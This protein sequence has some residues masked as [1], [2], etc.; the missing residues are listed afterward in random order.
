MQ[1]RHVSGFTATLLVTSAALCAIRV[2]GMVEP[3]AR[4]HAIHR[5]AAVKDSLHGNSRFEGCAVALPCY[6]H[7]LTSDDLPIERASQ[8]VSSGFA[9]DED[10][11]RLIPTP[12]TEMALN[13]LDAVRASTLALAVGGFLSGCGGGGSDEGPTS[14]D[15]AAG[16]SST[17]AGA[18]SASSSDG[19]AAASG[20]GTDDSVTVASTSAPPSDSTPTLP[21]SSSS[22]STG[23]QGGGGTKVAARSG[24]AMNLGLLAYYS[25][26]APTIDVMK[27]AGDWLTQCSTAN[28]K[29]CTGFASGASSWDTK[30]EAALDL[31]PNGWVRSL[32]DSGDGVHKFRSVTTLL[33]SNN[34]LPPGRYTVRYDGAGTIT[35]SGA[36]KVAGGSSS[37]RD[38]LDLKDTANNFYLT[39]T[40]TDP[41]NYIRNIRVYLPGGACANDLTVFA[42]SAA[43]CTSATGAYVPFESFPAS[44]P[45]SPDFIQ[46]I[47]GFR[48]LRFMDWGKTN[49]TALTS[50]AQRTPATARTWAGANGAPLEAM[51]DLANFIGA[52]A[53]MNVPPHADD[54]YATQLGKLAAA[55][56]TGVSKLDLE[57]GNEPWNYS[58]PASTWM[59]TQAKTRW[60][61][62]VSAGVDAY[63]L[64]DNWYALRL[65]QVCTAAKAAYSGTRCVANSQVANAWITTQILTCPQAAVELGHACAKS[66]DAVA[67]APYFG[68]YISQAKLRSA[69]TP[70]Y[71]DADG[72]L[73][74]LFQEITGTDASGNAATAALAAVGSGASGGSLGQVK[75]WMVATKAATD[76]QGVAMWAYEGGQHLLM[77]PGDSDTRLQALFV[78]ANRDPRMGA[79]YSRLMGDWQAVGGQTF[80]YYTHVGAP[81]I[82]GMW[83]LKEGMADNANPKWLA[84][85][86]AK[87]AACTWSGC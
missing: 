48:A 74:R 55:H 61:A 79:A 67:V 85:G 1:S 57:Y 27:R 72:G 66:I 64:Q 30:E 31:D 56:L 50:W 16:L 39:I 60:A 84:A 26:E 22:G 10:L 49:T 9:V 80:A 68:Q 70:W 20:T 82:Y 41:K 32:P 62:K 81:S 11:L 76:A 54:D 52:D 4:P 17:Y 46:D 14:T 33:G 53:W 87:A 36:T 37:G 28:N 34:A 23:L 2:T 51:L 71:A 69:V 83:G 73:G 35:Y 7:S 15:S 63:T 13:L 29:N 8:H 18:S 3:I 78:A 6:L 45:W 5:E 77:P 21:V 24:A 65:V 25:A 58:F 43:A 42:S 19:G 44:Q 40:A 38:V 12:V 47:K 86:R 75:G 59:Q